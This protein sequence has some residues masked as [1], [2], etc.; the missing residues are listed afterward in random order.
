[1]GVKTL[2]KTIRDEIRS[3]FEEDISKYRTDKLIEDV[4]RFLN[5]TETPPEKVTRYN[6]Q[7]STPIRHEVYLDVSDGIEVPVKDQDSFGFSIDKIVQ[8]ENG[9]CVSFSTS[10]S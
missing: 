4:V 5:R 3:V 9:F 8:N 7:N 10:K 2:R 1:M 6:I